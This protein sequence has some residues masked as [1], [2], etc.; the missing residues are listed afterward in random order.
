ML[1]K[2]KKIDGVELVENAS[3]K[4]YNTYR[5]ETVARYLVFPDN[6]EN[7]REL[8]MFLEREKQGIAI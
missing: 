7:L 1:G 4:R 8:V 3:L 6:R 2:I 5:L